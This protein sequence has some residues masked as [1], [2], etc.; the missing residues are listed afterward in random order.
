RTVFQLLGI[1]AIA[2]LVCT[3]VPQGEDP[4]SYYERYGRF[5]A[6]VITRLGLDHVHTTVWFQGLIA[7]LLLSLAACS[8]R[9]WKEASQRWRL[10][11]AA[12]VVGRTRGNARLNCLSSLAATDAVAAAAPAF[13]KHGYRLLDLGAVGE[14]RLFYV[15]KHRLSAWGQALA[16]Y[17]VFL[18]ALGSV[19]G[20]IHGLSLDQNIN[21]MEGDTYRSEDG[22]I[23]FAVKLDRF[24]IV[25]DPANGSVKNYYSEVRIIDGEK[26]VLSDKISVN[27]PLR[28]R[29]YFLSQSDWGLGEAQIEVTS[30]GKTQQYAFP[31]QR[32]A[33]PGT[34]AEA[35]MWGVPQEDGVLRLPGGHSAL[36]AAGFY[37]DAVRKDGQVTQLSTEYPGTPALSLTYVSGIPGGKPTGPAE[38][39]PKHGM[40]DLGWLLPGET[41]TLDDGTVKFVG[42]TKSTGL[43]VRKDFGLPLVWIGFLASMI[44]LSMIFYFPLQRSIVAFEAR[45]QGRTLLTLAPYGRAG[46]L[47]DDS[48]AVWQDMLKE[49]GGTVVAGSGAGA[50]QEESTSE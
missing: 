16:H 23:P 35:S 41:K 38:G 37:A 19:L 33:C 15:H 48:S 39:P 32:G 21:I 18:V 6:N 26:E 34:D 9:L 43:G 42:I 3:V 44:G 29:G 4:Q 11:T 5:L 22:A 50:E 24:S 45:G 8:G 27:H 20:S 14:K 28:Y 10:P 47:A 7:V 13:R 17:S 49:V 31:L 30:G 2:V 12:A 46:D 25:Q 1:I 36:V 40:S